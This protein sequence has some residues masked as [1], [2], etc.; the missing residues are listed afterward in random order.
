MKLFRDPHLPWD[1]IYPYDALSDALVKQGCA[2][3]TP[4]SAIATVKDAFFDLMS[5]QPDMAQRAAWDQL[6]TAQNRMAVDFFLYPVDDH[7]NGDSLEFLSS[8]ELPVY[9]PDFRELATIQPADVSAFPEPAA[10][11]DVPPLD[12]GE[13]RLDLLAWT[14][15]DDE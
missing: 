6:R 12:I 4:E 13:I 5:T 1:G 14:G 7:G 9:L 11:R 8:V 2:P 10:V 3:V 15:G